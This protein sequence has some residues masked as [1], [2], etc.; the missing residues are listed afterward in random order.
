MTTLIWAVIALHILLHES[1]HWA[2]GHHY[3]AQWRGVRLRW[4]SL[5]LRMVI[6]QDTPRHLLWIALAGP[7]VDSVFFLT[8]LVGAFWT[9]GHNEF[10]VF[11]AIWFTLIMFLNATPW[12]PG[13]DGQ[14][15]WYFR[16]VLFQEKNTNPSK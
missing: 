4:Y 8:F 14:R 9:G 12:I 10:W 2:V 11:G 1:A 5:A 16:S 13:S 3:G 6:P 15:V 7:A